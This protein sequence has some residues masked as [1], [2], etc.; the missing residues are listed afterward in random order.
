MTKFPLTKFLIWRS[1]FAMTV[2]AIFFA[3]FFTIMFSAENLTDVLL[4]RAAR[5]SW[6]SIHAVVGAACVISVV[7]A[8]FARTI[9]P[10][11]QNK[12]IVQTVA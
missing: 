8:I 5:R 7:L 9:K 11:K 1:P 12:A 10:K 6:S 4:T 2:C 3:I